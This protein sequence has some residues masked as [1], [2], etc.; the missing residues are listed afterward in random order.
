MEN[1]DIFILNLNVNQVTDTTSLKSLSDRCFK[2]ETL[3]SHLFEV[4]S[5]LLTM[6]RPIYYQY[7]T[8]QTTV[9]FLDIFSGQQFLPKQVGLRNLNISLSLKPFFSF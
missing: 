4:I 9:T 7:I 6:V 2:F 8:K 3:F 5:S 1:L